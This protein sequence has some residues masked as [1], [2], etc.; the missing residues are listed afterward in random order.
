MYRPSCRLEFFRG[1][2]SPNNIF[3]GN[4]VGCVAK[5]SQLVIHV[6]REQKLKLEMIFLT[7]YVFFLTCFH[8]P[9]KARNKQLSQKLSR[10]FFLCNFLLFCFCVFSFC[11]TSCTSKHGTV[12]PNLTFSFLIA[13]SSPWN[14]FY[15]LLTP[16]FSG[17]R[18]Y[19]FK[20]E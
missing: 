6:K 15:P 16:K 11:Q 3:S 8:F 12:N 5:W 2:R 18:I 14:H 7:Q 17:L 19:Y 4:F 13:P 10:K 1:N 20:V 9:C